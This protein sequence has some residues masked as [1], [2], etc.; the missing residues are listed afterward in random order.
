MSGYFEDHGLTLIANG[1]GIVPIPKGSKSPGLRIGEGDAAKPF[2]WQLDYART[3]EQFKVMIDRGWGKHGVG[4]VAKDTPAID[5]D[6]LDKDIV[7]KLVDWAEHTFGVTFPQRVGKAPKTLLM[8]STEK[9]FG[10][11]MSASYYN[12]D[13]PEWTPGRRYMKV[14]VLAD[15]QQFVAYH[16]HPD[17]G[18]PYQWTTDDT[19]LNTPVIDLPL[20][21]VDQVQDVCREFERLAEEAGW[22]KKAESSSSTT[23]GDADY[24]PLME[25]PPPT[26]S[27][28]EVDR[29]KSALT[30]IKTKISEYSYEQWRDLIFALK[31]TKWDCAYE[32][33]KDVSEASDLHNEK[34]FEKVWRG[35]EKKEARANK[36]TLAS[37]YQQA[38]TTAGWD[39]TRTKTEAEELEDYE[40][41]ARMCARLEG[42]A[43]DD[44]F[45][46]LPKIFR[47]MGDAN[48]TPVNEDRL[49]KLI[50]KFTGITLPTLRT[51][52]RNAKKSAEDG[53]GTHAAYAAALI[54]N[55]K[56]DNGVA[57]IGVEGQIFSFD[58]DDRV[59]RGK[60][61]ADFAVDVADEF[62][63]RENCIRR[64]DYT[65]IAAQAYAAVSQGKADF[66]N[67]APIG[68]A[69][70]GVFYKVDDEGQVVKEELRAEH[71]QR[72]AFDIRPIVGDMPMF[73]K[74]LDDA[75]GGNYKDEQVQL[76]QEVIGAT[77]LG[78]MANYEKVVMM[79]GPGRAGKG[80][81]LKIIESLIPPEARSAVSPFKWDREYYLADLAGKRLNVVGEM[82]DDEAIPSAHFK[83][84]TG[85]D[86]LTGRHPTGRPFNFRNQ[87]ANIFNGN[88]FIYTKDHSPAFYSRWLLM[89][90]KN[91]RVGRENE[92]QVDLAQKIIEHERP[93]IL[94][95]AL[96]GAK[97][98]QS[99]GHFVVTTPQRL[100]MLEWQRRTSTLLEFIQDT[101]HCEMG[102]GPKF[103]TARSFFYSEYA[104]W[105]KDSNRK[106][107][108]KQKLFDELEQE[109]T[110][111]LGIS[112]GFMHG[113]VNC[114][115]GVHI[116][117][118]DG[119]MFTDLEDDPDEI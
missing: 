23:A 82:P 31:W 109:Q 55:L 83:S 118:G 96:Q 103:V 107:M 38:K 15:G 45:R 29:V 61:T 93:A 75:F 68:L 59:W 98:L 90:F 71:R 30:A 104:Q 32:L 9:H 112:T 62:D 78:I 43:E 21:T 42:M 25:I 35:A 65:A 111:L 40:K 108:G 79:K 91:S 110:K 3:P 94:A 41:M 37:L 60:I 54:R 81:L 52:L 4:I 70:R 116:K 53:G 36:V 76:L 14:E 77:V 100:M 47:E 28:F 51:E 101:D 18:R 16:M 50:G 72:V 89:S 27:T 13:H 6:V 80:T 99:R 22:E 12:G 56:K 11:I 1:Y 24:D 17:T 34:E 74:L 119:G 95:W 86:T 113:G 64:N 69:C 49:L 97:A 19:P 39:A 88:H 10:K 87:A 46:L 44:K 73:N 84:V 105:C 48:L 114:V 20:L 85:R 106:P 67:K 66:F 63:G 7:E 92:Q 33:A 5:I 8:F 57:P 115:R 117:R 2:A 26:E 102:K 58:T